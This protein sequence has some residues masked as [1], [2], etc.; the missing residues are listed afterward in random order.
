MTE[1]L[2]ADASGKEDWLFCQKEENLPI[3]VV[4]TNKRL[5]IFS[6]LKNC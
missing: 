3:L 4:Q 1:N 2:T 5:L 6:I